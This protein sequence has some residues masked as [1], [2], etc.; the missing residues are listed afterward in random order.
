MC[1]STVFLEANGVVTEAMKDVTRIVMRG[2]QAI[3]TNIIGDQVVLD[4]VVLKEA[5]L[6]SH[7]IVF[8]RLSD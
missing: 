2:S 6:L 7:G 5:N 8:R 3:C 4:N 1:E